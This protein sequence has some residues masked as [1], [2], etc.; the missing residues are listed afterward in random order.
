MNILPFIQ[1]LA[2][3]LCCSYSLGELLSLHN[4]NN[5][6]IPDGIIYF[7]ERPFVI[8]EDKNSKNS[9]RYKKVDYEIARIQDYLGIKWSILLDDDIFYLRPLLGDFKNIE[10]F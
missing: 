4:R 8:I 9:K 5:Y 6:F 3:E 2:N 10:T 1:N 7:D